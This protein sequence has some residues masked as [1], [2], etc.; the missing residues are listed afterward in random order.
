MI[1]AVVDAVLNTRMQRIGL[2]ATDATLA[3]NLYKNKLEEHGLTFIRPTI[4]GQK[5]LW[6]VFIL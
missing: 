2:L 3:T 1:D 6:K 5:K 4:Q